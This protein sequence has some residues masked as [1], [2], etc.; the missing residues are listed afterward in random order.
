VEA[1][2]TLF[3]ESQPKPAGGA[4]SEEWLNW[5]VGIVLTMLNGGGIIKVST[6]VKSTNT[7]QFLKKP[8]F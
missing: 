7:P 1:V 2:V 4:K 8:V 6:L 5:E 3:S